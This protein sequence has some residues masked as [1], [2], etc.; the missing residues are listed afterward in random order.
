MKTSDSLKSI[1]PA[2][3]KAQ[4]AIKSA[5]KDSTNPHY[6]SKYAD[7]SAVIEAVKGPLNDNGILFQQPPEEM[8]D[9]QLFVTTRLQ[10]ESGEFMEA[11]ASCPLPKQ[12]PQGYG[13]AL[14]YMRRYA[15]GA[16]LGVPAEDDDGNGAT[17][18]EP[19]KIA[20]E[21][22]GTPV[23]RAPDFQVMKPDTE[24]QIRFYVGIPKG[25]ALIEQ[26]LAKKELLSVDDFSE[27]LAVKTISWI[28]SELKK[29]NK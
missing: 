17:H 22:K 26:V 1:A 25:R 2:L 6:R 20:V 13:S 16:F 27:E 18:R 23:V 15:L 9:G 8:R 24:K 5:L 28:E 29:E 7:V 12:D 19:S 10:H 4:R 21:S 14:T 11:T 3:L